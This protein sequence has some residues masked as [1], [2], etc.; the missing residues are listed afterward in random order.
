MQVG[1]ASVLAESARRGATSELLAIQTA[2]FRIRE[3]TASNDPYTLTT[4]FVSLFVPA[5]PL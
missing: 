1:D 4:D 2:T 3:I 5:S